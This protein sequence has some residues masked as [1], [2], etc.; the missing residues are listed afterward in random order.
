M[1]FPE[2]AA[3]AKV[4]ASPRK[5]ALP[6]GPPPTTKDDLRK[7]N[8]VPDLRYLAVIAPDPGLRAYSP[9]KRKEM[10]HLLVAGR[11]MRLQEWILPSSPSDSPNITLT[12]LSIYC[13]Y[14]FICCG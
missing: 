6:T 11:G 13:L 10:N 1:L 14:V 9:S 7:K 3:Y 5:A 2:T 8:K 12:A 4:P